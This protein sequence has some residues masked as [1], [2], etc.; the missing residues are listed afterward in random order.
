MGKVISLHI[1]VNVILL[2][3]EIK[4]WLFSE[5][6]KWKK[7]IKRCWYKMDLTEG[8]SWNTIQWICILGRGDVWTSLKC[9]KS[10]NCLF[11][12]TNIETLLTFVG[13]IPMLHEMNN[14]VKMA[15]SR[16]MY[17]VE[18][19]RTRKLT[20]LALDNLYIMEDSFT[21]LAFTNWRKIINIEN[22]EFLLSLMK[23][24]CYVW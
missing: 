1:S 18:Y 9:R 21:D 17:I 3:Y 22:D 23:K 15:Q 19:T 16:T 13:I 4:V 14:L 2:F 5:E 20:C 11:L 7:N 6:K 10:S 24:G 8:T 12:L